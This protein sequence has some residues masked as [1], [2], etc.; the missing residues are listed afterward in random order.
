MIAANEM[1]GWW[2]YSGSIEIMEHPTNEVVNIYGTIDTK[3]YSFLGI[4]HPDTHSI[5]VPDAETAFHTYAI[6][7]S[8]DTI[9]YYVD[10]NKYFSYINNHTGF[11]TWP[12]DQSFYII[13]DVAV[14]GGWVGNPNESTVFPAIMEVDYVRVY[15]KLE[16]IQILGKDAVTPNSKEISYSVP[17]LDS[18]CYSWTVSPGALIVSG[19]NTHQINVEWGSDSGNVS[20][21]ITINSNSQIKN[22]P[23][24]VSDN[25]I[26]NP[27]FEKGGKYWNSNITT[28][29]ELKQPRGSYKFVSPPLSHTKRAIKINIPKLLTYPWDFQLSQ[30]GLAMKYNKQYNVS[31][32]AKSDVSGNKLKATIVIPKYLGSSN[33]VLYGKEFILTNQWTQ[34][35]F[36][37]TSDEDIEGALNMD[38]GYQVGTYY[39]DDFSLLR[40]NNSSG[41][42]STLAPKIL[43]D[44]FLSQNYPNPCSSTTAITFSLTY[45]QIVTLKVYDIHGREVAMLVN[46]VKKSGKYTVTFD[47]KKLS[48]GIYFYQFI[49]GNIIQT[50]KCLVLK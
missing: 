47:T 11:E 22:Y 32:W 31:F 37:F 20:A 16:D 40:Q 33:Y 4:G 21:V 42:D 43:P 48:N 12:F 34:Y 2:P 14:G 6:E 24:D 38:I 29:N 26:K 28:F 8:E 17:L 3:N 19:Q 7:W 35:A 45:Q 39:F 13:L 1:Y 44:Y 15:Q 46:E 50:R 10:D 27:G 18:A 9:D 25:L 36:R 5:Q 30:I 49:A 23:V 41:S